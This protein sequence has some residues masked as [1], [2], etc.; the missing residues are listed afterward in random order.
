KNEPKNQVTSQYR[1]AF[2]PWY[3]AYGK[4]VSLEHKCAD[5][6]TLCHDAS[7]EG[8]MFGNL[9]L[10]TP[11]PEGVQGV[12]KDAAREFLRRR[13]KADNKPKHVWRDG[14][15]RRFTSFVVTS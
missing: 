13:G 14:E 11:L 8:S 12:N 2:Y 15:N 9:G 3:P 5:G 6:N 7:Y 4:Y 1:T 10:E